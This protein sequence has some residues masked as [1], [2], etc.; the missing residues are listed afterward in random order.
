[1]G[2]DATIGFTTD[3]PAGCTG[4]STTQ[5]E[6]LFGNVVSNGSLPAGNF[7]VVLRDG[8]NSI[9]ASECFVVVEPS[10][11]NLDIQPTNISCFEGGIILLDVTGGTS[12]FTYAWS[13]FSTEEDRFNLPAG[14]Y[15]VTV[16]DAAGC[17][18]IS[19]PIVIINTCLLYTSPSPRDKRQSRM[20]SSA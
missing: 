16:T 3:F 4:P 1:M 7:C 14:T 2:S 19:P 20:P 5:I 6:D 18:A 11:I 10:Q 8:N 9:V 13:D 12:P 15:T 17:Q